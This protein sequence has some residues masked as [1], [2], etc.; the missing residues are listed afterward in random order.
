LEGHKPWST[1]ENLSVGENKP[2]VIDPTRLPLPVVVFNASEQAIDEGQSIKLSWSSRD[3]DH[4]SITDIGSVPANGDRMV[5][6]SKSVTYVLTATGPGGDTVSKVSVSVHAKVVPK[7]SANLTADSLNLEQGQSTTLHWSTQNATDISISGLGSV[8]DSGSK[9][10]TPSGNTRYILTASS[11]GGSVESSVTVTVSAKSA[12]EPSHES[13]SNDA[14]EIERVVN[15]FTDLYSHMVVEDLKQVWPSVDSKTLSKY[16][17]GLKGVQRVD[18]ADSCVGA[19]NFTSA[20]TAEWSCAE[21]V[22]FVRDGKRQSPVV[23]KFHYT[24]AKSEGK[25]YITGRRG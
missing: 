25:W 1:V 6:P 23:A 8:Q 7:P 17:D 11:A 14:Q 3:A 18:V 9:T 24:F 20:N 12:P 19:P 4:V 15:R 10:V 13:A 5:T 16:R 2:V 22:T 21:T